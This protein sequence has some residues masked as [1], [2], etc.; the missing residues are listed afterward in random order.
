[1][2][3]TNKETD[4]IIKDLIKFGLLEVEIDEERE[5]YKF[6]KYG[7]KIEHMCSREAFLEGT[8]RGKK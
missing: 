1:M 8:K 2:T 7:N 6:T 3:H 4:R 5:Y